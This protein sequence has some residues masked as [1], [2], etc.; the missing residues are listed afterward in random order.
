MAIQEKVKKAF[1]GRHKLVL[2][3]FSTFFLAL[4]LFTA[5]STQSGYRAEALEVK[6]AKTLVDVVKEGE[7][8][9]AYGEVWFHLRE[10]IQIQHNLTIGENDYIYLWKPWKDLKASN[11]GWLT[12]EN[13][14]Y[15][16][17]VNLDHSY[18]LIFDKIAGRDLLVYDDEIEDPINIL[19]GS[20]IGFSDHSGN[21][22]DFFATTAIHDLDGIG[23]YQILWEDA[24]KGFLLVGTEGWDYQPEDHTRG[25]DVEAEVVFGLFA[26]KPYFIDATEINNLQRMDLFTTNIPYKDPDEVVKSWV[27]VGDYDYAVITGG[28]LDHLNAEWWRPWYKVR[29]INDQ[30]RKVWHFGSAQFSKMFPTHRLIGQKTGGGIVFSLPQ[31]RF[32]FDESLGAYG[33]QVVGEF[34]LVVEEPRKAVGFSVEPVNEYEYFYDEESFREEY[35]ESMVHICE[36]YSL[37]CPD[38]PLD[39]HNWVTKRFAYVITPVGDWYDPE[40]NLVY[41]EVWNQADQGLEDFK[42]YEEVIYDQMERTK[43]LTMI[44]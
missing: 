40:T 25:Y 28:D 44:G 4:L 17:N 19:T 37:T 43:P 22:P 15:R 38:Q 10:P 9:K 2:L 42:I 33:D 31:G 5:V 7:M 30:G 8:K 41:K 6:K 26:D 1:K 39:W 21:N 11:K 29:T 35:M 3:T 36:K 24:E 32:R 34:L 16:I 20:D 12:M 13:R 18:Y 23:R 14:F 27:I